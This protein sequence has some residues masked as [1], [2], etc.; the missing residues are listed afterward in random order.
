M[1]SNNEVKYTSFFTRLLVFLVDIFIVSLLTYI[2][3]FVVN[4][5]GKPILLILILWLYF[6]IMISRWST[7]IGGKLF[8][9]KVF[10]VNTSTLS[11]L[12]VSLRFF[13]SILPFVLYLYFRNI[14]HVMS[15]PPSPE[16]QML[17]QLIFILIPFTM[18]LTKKRQMLHDVIVKSMVIDVNKKLQIG[19]TSKY[20]IVG[21]GQQILRVLGT[22]FVLII[23]GYI[24]V[25]TSV[26]YMIGKQS[27]NVY[28][29]SFHV[30]YTTKDFNDSRIIFYNKE[31]EQYSKAFVSA[32]GMYDVFA[33]DTKRDLALNC[34]QA[35]LKEHNV[36][37]WI[38]M[39]SSFRKNARNLYAKTKEQINKSKKNTDYM[40]HHFYDY[41]LNEVNNIENEIANI[42][43]IDKN[44]ETCHKSLPIEKMYK[45]F[46]FKYIT[47]RKEALKKY[48]YEYKKAKPNGVL[49]KKFYK[50][51]LDKTK[52]WLEM[53]LKEQPGYFVYL[54]KLEEKKQGFIW[55][56]V[57]KQKGHRIE[58]FNGVNV[59]IK[60]DLGETPL[61]LAVKNKNQRVLR[62]F[63]KTIVDVH[64]KDN[65]G[66]SAFDYIPIKN[67]KMME[68]LKKLEAEQ[69]V[70]ED[71]V[72]FHVR[73]TNKRKEVE[74]YINGGECAEFK[75]P[76]D[77]I[78]Q[79]IREYK[80]SKGIKMWK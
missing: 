78:C 34:I 3:H 51:E 1:E 39:G 73:I 27:N 31:L 15:P 46:V 37:E 48:K 67:S 23:G 29:N 47:N 49:N 68:S 60:N 40:G 33:A 19:E 24:L 16:I 75:F 50:K 52:I 65:N 32:D 20:T 28:N 38:E 44:G 2:V 17:P 77:M 4:I 21:R 41:D 59:N 42:W 35:S 6:S 26:F 10:G 66:K 69:I 70:R 56:S 57:K 7:T 22:V 74:I 13:L 71:A 79:H 53:L 9:V 45:M 14:Q 12:K 5:E 43:D 62:F 55:E 61:I 54:K 58:S 63:R 18:Y 30:K 72:V 11:F 36:S 76:K 25:Y 80:N 8:G 64:M